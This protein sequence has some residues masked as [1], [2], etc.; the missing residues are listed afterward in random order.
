[1]GW[2]K[3]PTQAPVIQPQA[4]PEV[5]VEAILKPVFSMMEESTNMT[6]RM[7][8]EN[9]ARLAAMSTPDLTDVSSIDWDTEN[10]TLK[11][12]IAKQVDVEEAKRKGVLGTIHTLYGED[13]EE[14]PTLGSLLTSGD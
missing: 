13:E 2:G 3:T 4:A 7:V 12:K 1:M 9:N 6:M 8:E 10:N 11:E 5:D 14:P